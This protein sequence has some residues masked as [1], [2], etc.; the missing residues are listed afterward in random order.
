MLQ[1][2]RGDRFHH[3]PDLQRRAALAADRALRRSRCAEASVLRIVGVPLFTGFMYAPVGSYI[4]R[5][6]RLFDLRFEQH[7]PTAYVFA[8]AITIYINFFAHHDVVDTRLML[9]AA[10]AAPFART[11]VRFRVWRA[12]RSMPLLLGFV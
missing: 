9:L 3:P 5:A 1:R 12:W 4:A 10:T 7:P 2:F 6:W 8:L 11:R